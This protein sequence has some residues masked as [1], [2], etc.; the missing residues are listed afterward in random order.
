MN[1]FYLRFSKTLPES[2]LRSSPS[3]LL[4]A[5]RSAGMPSTI[6]RRKL[7][8]VPTTNPNL[9]PYL[10]DK[11]PPAIPGSFD[12]QLKIISQAMNLSNTQ[13]S[14]SG[15]IFRY[16]IAIKYRVPLSIGIR[17]FPLISKSLLRERREKEQA[18]LNTP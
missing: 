14:D 10:I 12:K 8:I 4:R 9:A 2:V 13:P 6:P 7:P 18:K 11:L 3:L 16:N 15:Q 1:K 17:Y 5:G